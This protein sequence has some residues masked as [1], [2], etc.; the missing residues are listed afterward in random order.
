MRAFVTL[1]LAIYLLCELSIMRWLK[2]KAFMPLSWANLKA[3]H[4]MF[5][6]EVI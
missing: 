5:Y 1:P 6:K 3:L 2:H 4:R